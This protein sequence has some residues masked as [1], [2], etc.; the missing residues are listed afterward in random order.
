[1]V[2]VV[3][4]MALGA[5]AG[6]GAGLAVAVGVLFRRDRRRAEE[7]K[8]L[9]AEITEL[10]IQQAT[11][12]LTALCGPDPPPDGDGD[13]DGGSTRP[14]DRRRRWRVIDGGA[15]TIAAT[16]ATLAAAASFG[17]DQ[18]R[19]QP[20][21][22]AVTAATAV[23]G[24]ATITLLHATSPTPPGGR[25][26]PDRADDSHVSPTSHPETSASPA[27]PSPEPSSETTASADSVRPG[28]SSPGM[29]A[30][31]PADVSP[32]PASSPPGLEGPAAPPPS[33]A[34]GFGA[35]GR[36]AA[37]PRP[38]VTGPDDPA[39]PPVG[40]GGPD[41]VPSP[42]AQRPPRGLLGVCVRA[43]VEPIADVNVCL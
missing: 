42:N 33:Q 35:G 4:A 20:V 17:R 31:R 40:G 6:L 38:E 36:P 14:E 28:P 30:A 27:Q 7:I 16:G 29:P 37:P 10:R 21:V 5:V 2:D 25:D 22:A 34:P 43:E 39:P 13:G 41:A 8:A 1:M 24:L 12:K 18:L 32:S 11:E 23:A 15:A 3:L 9:R 19:A 26:V